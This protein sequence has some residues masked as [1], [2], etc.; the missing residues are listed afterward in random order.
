MALAFG[1][2]AGTS[3]AQPLL[4][5]VHT[6]SRVAP[7]IE[8]SFVVA[9]AGGYDLQLTD[10]GAPAAFTSLRLI[11]TRGSEIVAQTNAPGPL[12]FDAVADTYEVH[13]LGSP[14]AADGSGTFGVQVVPTGGGSPVLDFADAINAPAPAGDP[15]V[16]TLQTQFDVSVPGAY[17]V[18]LTDFAFPAAFAT[19]TLNIIGPGGA[20][21]FAS[22][23]TAPGSYPFTAVAGT[24][25]LFVITKVQSPPDSGSYGLQIGDGTH[26]LYSDARAV[27][28][29][30]DAG[31]PSATFTADV[32]AA[33][34]YR[35]TL[36]DFQFPAP[37][38]SVQLNV[39]QGGTSLG[40]LGM[41]GTLDVAAAVGP[42]FVSAIAQP[43][44]AGGNGL[45]GVQLAPVGA[46]PALLDVTQGA[47]PLFD[48]RFVDVTQAGSYDVTL[49]DLG[50]PATFSDLALAATRGPDRLGLIF[51][52]GTF[53]FDA[54]PGRYYLNFIAVPNATAKAGTYGLSVSPTPPAPVV[55]LTANPAT[56]ASGGTTSLTWSATDATSCTA[57]G[58]WSGSKN[59]TGSE[60]SAALTS[61]SAFTLTCNGPGGSGSKTVNVGIAA[62]GNSGGGGALGV[63]ESMLF[64]SGL[65]LRAR[66]RH[67][68][69]MAAGYRH[70]R[71]AGV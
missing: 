14:N 21:V 10:F 54:T 1:A 69:Y 15:T 19:L 59:T 67:S 36:T 16:T 9:S 2:M 55:T 38:Q 56:V 29:Q 53:S 6:L 51:G 11:V 28:T 39:T 18:E 68:L 71:S 8:R 61:A 7:A 20:S 12:H 44:P 30:S 32:T 27:S 5:E 65:W 42:I 37:L 60:T 17:S 13:V 63:F 57:S 47:G 34:T 45:Y 31:T 41:A 43:A 26:V 62:P 23:P 50:F 66:R 3:R 33:G 22:P 48:A 4:G 40:T 58:A 49:S 24:Y 70:C 64:A 46:G 35:V 52:G 25:N